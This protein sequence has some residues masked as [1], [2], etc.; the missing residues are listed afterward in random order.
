[1]RSDL[2]RDNQHYPSVQID[3]Y[4]SVVVNSEV[5]ERLKKLLLKKVVVNQAF[6]AIK[7]KLAM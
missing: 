4:Q 5:N 3:D 2:T 1:M 6:K 7:L